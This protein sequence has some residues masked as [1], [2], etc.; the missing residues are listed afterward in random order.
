MKK[1]HL[2]GLGLMCPIFLLSACIAQKTPQDVAQAFWESV[3]R[4]DA[5]KAVKYSTLT[6]AQE[7]D[8]FSGNWSNFRLSFGRVVIDG[9]NANIVSKFSRPDDTGTQSRRFVTYLVYHNDEWLVD[10]FRTGKALRGSAL[11]N[12]FEQF[13]QL[14]NEISEQLRASSKDFSE[15]MERMNE[16]F[17]E[18]SGTITQQAS[19]SLRRYGKQLRRNIRELADSVQRALEEQERRLSDRDRSVLT[20]VVSDLNEGGVNLSRPTIQSITDAGKSVRTAQRQLAS[21]DDEVVGQYKKQWRELEET[22]EGEMR[23]ILE[24]LTLSAEG[25]T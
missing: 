24:E 25:K 15:D 2:L 17:A 1:F 12:L 23:R 5:K 13:D 8:G 21:T 22:F 10:Y 7:Y 3:I 20:E 18:L 9:D 6:D 11:A 4:N 19:E 14:G 16:Q